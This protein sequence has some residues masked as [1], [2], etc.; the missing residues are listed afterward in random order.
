MIDL[1]RAL[2]RPLGY[3]DGFV[4]ANTFLIDM[5]RWVDY[6]VLHGRGKTKEATLVLEKGFGGISWSLGSGKDGVFAGFRVV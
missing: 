1:E 4:H 3:L 6:F 5:D 2:W